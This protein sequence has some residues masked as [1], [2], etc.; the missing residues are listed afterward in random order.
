MKEKND[1]Y[2]HCWLEGV[3]KAVKDDE[4][5]NPNEMESLNEPLITDPGNFKTGNFCFLYINRS[6]IFFFRSRSK[7]RGIAPKMRGTEEEKIWLG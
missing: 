3:E 4:I 2:I 6:L 1:K 7:R 5:V